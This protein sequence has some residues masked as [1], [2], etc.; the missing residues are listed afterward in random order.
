MVV[1]KMKSHI[2]SLLLLLLT[3]FS[4]SSAAANTGLALVIYEKGNATPVFECWLTDKPTVTF[5]NGKLTATAPSGT[6]TLEFTNVARMEFEEKEEIITDVEEELAEELSPATLR[7]QFLDSQTAL[8]EG[9][10]DGDTARLYAIDGRVVPAEME[11]SGSR[12]T[13]YLGNL[14]QGVY[15]IRIGNQSFKIYKKS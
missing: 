4:L 8:I 1:I 3:A 13:I 6:Y 10:H 11:R 5:N 2:K 9:I 12:L 15:I 7:L 14:P